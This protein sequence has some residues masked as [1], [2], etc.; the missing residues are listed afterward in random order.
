MAVSII[1]YQVGSSV[2]WN[3]SYVVLFLSVACSSGFHVLVLLIRCRQCAVIPFLRTVVLVNTVLMVDVF[4]FSCCWRC[5]TAAAVSIGGCIS[6]VVDLS[7]Y[8]LLVGLYLSDNK[9]VLD[10]LNILYC[11][12]PSG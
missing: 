11:Y 9:D 1:L 6:S 12:K 8:T 2:F 7:P 5:P 10:G 4:R 3:R